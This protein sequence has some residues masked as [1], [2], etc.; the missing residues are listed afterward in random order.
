MKAVDINIVINLF[1][2]GTH[3]DA[4]GKL[5]SSD[6]HWILPDL[7]IHEMTNVVATYVK[8]SGIALDDGEKILE[9]ACQYFLETTY[10]LPMTVVLKT[11][12]EYDISGYDAAYIAL[13]RN[14]K[15]PLIT[16]DKKLAN[17]VPEFTEILPGV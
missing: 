2:E 10:S 7:W 15:V 3:S 1:I 4:T 14:N 6:R 9:S 8:Q 16:L 13:A 17:K 12:I 11:S 5:F